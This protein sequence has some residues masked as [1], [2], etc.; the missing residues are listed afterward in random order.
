MIHFL[1][2]L[3]LPTVLIGQVAGGKG[4]KNSVLATLTDVSATVLYVRLFLIGA[5]VLAAVLLS[6]WFINKRRAQA[7]K[8]TLSRII[9]LLDT[10]LTCC[11]Q[12]KA[13]RNKKLDRET[14]RESK[15]Q[16]ITKLL[17]VLEADGVVK[18]LGDDV[19]KRMIMAIRIIETDAVSLTEQSAIADRWLRTIDILAR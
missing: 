17:N 8:V 15:Q 12:L 19:Q 5:T 3:G 4:I 18:T 13:T 7:R 11:V 16:A 6:I 2:L 10:V 1:A 14:I 9:A